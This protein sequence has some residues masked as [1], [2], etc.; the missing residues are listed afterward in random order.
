MSGAKD[1]IST[2]TTL[3]E[4]VDAF[5]IDTDINIGKVDV[6]KNL[7]FKFKF[8]LLY[9]FQYEILLNNIIIL[10]KIMTSA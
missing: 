6:N 10:I 2:I 7:Y 3:E 8:N 1:A 4:S 5:L 9:N